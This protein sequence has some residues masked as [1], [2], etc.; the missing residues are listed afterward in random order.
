MAPQTPT[1][2]GLEHQEGRQT[3]GPQMAHATLPHS[4]A[5]SKMVGQAR[6]ENPEQGH[7]KSFA[8]SE[9]PTGLSPDSPS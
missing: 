1:D 5:V 6:R 9:G 7:K 2:P 8:S 4:L 3:D